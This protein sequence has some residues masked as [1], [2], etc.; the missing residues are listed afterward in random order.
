MPEIPDS[1]EPKRTGVDDFPA[2]MNA[3]QAG[4][5]LG[6]STWA[7]REYA[8]QGLIPHRRI[9][10]R[11]VFSRDALLKWLEGDAD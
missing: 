5:F 10:R 2:V 9:G 4:A 6:V 1:E 7:V 8:R 3:D 11:Y